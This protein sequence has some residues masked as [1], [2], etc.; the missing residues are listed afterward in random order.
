M[1]FGTMPTL[2]ATF[3]KVLTDNKS[4]IVT[5]SGSSVDQF[6]RDPEGGD[7]AESRDS[8]IWIQVPIA[9]LDQEGILH[10]IVAT[11][12]KDS[13]NVNWAIHVGDSA[14]QAFN[15]TA[16]FTGTQWSYAAYR[17]LNYTHYPRVRGAYCYVK[18]SDV[19]NNRWLL[20]QI[21]ADV[22]SCGQRRVS[23]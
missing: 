3:P 9:G 5:F 8:Q 12:A 20:E 14:E 11:L 10:S 6:K 2:A 17:Y 21:T 23:G 4:S 19:S 1:S 13:A 7:V 15:S 18:V 16:A 22:V